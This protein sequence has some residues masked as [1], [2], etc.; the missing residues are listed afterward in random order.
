MRASGFVLTLQ[1]REQHIRREKGHI[2]HLHEPG[3]DGDRGDGVHGDAGTG[4]VPRGR[5]A[6]LPERPLSRGADRGHAW[7]R[8]GHGGEFFHEFTVSTPIPARAVVAQLLEHGILGGL[9]LGKVDPQLDHFMLVSTTELNNRSAIDRMV[10]SLP[11]Q[12]AS[13]ASRRQVTR[14][15]LVYSPAV[16]R[17]SIDRE[18]EMGRARLLRLPRH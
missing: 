7:L 5:S 16:A 1:T 12:R 9:D 11:D 15:G 14:D 8:R 18:R 4:G 10:V 13:P 3:I 6:Q 2:E 17:R